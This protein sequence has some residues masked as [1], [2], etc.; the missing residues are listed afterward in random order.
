MSIFLTGDTHGDL[1]RFTLAN[2]PREDWTFDDTLIVLG[3][4]GMIFHNDLRDQERLDRL[5]RLNFNLCFIDGNH[6]CFP[7]LNAYPVEEWNGGKVHRIRRNIR[8]LMRG[9]V[10]TIEGMTLFT[11]G[12]GH[13]IDKA[14]RREGRSWWP[15][16]MPS[17]AEYQEAWLNLKA[18]G[19][20]VDLILTHV[21]PAETLEALHQMGVIPSVDL[22][23]AELNSFLETVREQVSYG[24]WYFGHIH[25]DRTMWRSQTAVYYDIW[26][27]CSGEKLEG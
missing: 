21:P 17:Q 12:G 16:E 5:E 14:F 10:F 20:K 27:A 7:A 1:F 13:S 15:E 23:E 24:H 22:D 26:N 9:Q 2:M 8:H 11:M 19:L 6:E 3:D 18:N 25:L 4:F